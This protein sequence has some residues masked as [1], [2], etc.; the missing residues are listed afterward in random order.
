MT[1]IRPHSREG[2]LG[3]VVAASWLEQNGGSGQILIADAIEVL[4]R[5]PSE[6]RCLVPRQTT[7]ATFEA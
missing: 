1:P 6:V 4:R 7:F 3:I 2:R 5:A